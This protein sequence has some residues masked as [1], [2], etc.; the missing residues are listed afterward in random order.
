M[1]I[2]NTAWYRN[3]W[4]VLV[5]GTVE[6]ETFDAWEIFWPFATAGLSVLRT[7][8]SADFWWWT[9]SPSPQPGP[10]WSYQ[11]VGIQVS[12]TEDSYSTA[13]PFVPTLSEPNLDNRYKATVNEQA[14]FQQALPTAYD[15]TTGFPNQWTTYATVSTESA[16]SAAQRHFDSGQRVNGWVTVGPIARWVPVLGD[17]PSFACAITVAALIGEHT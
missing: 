5:S 8:V 14:N 1:P 15:A 11:P 13:P 17:S 9:D 7:R 3:A 4:T 12:F 16:D 10:G 2:G 6:M